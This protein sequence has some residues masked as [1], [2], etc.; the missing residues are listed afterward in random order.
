MKDKLVIIL[1]IKMFLK[2]WAITFVTNAMQFVT[3][4]VII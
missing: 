2:K 4:T 3:C 1:Q